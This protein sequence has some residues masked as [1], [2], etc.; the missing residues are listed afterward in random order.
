MTLTCNECGEPATHRYA[1]RLLEDGRV[2]DRGFVCDTHAEA[3][4]TWGR[5]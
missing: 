1:I 3:L 2:L 4:R 5:L